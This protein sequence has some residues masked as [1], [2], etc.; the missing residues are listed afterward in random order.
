MQ[1]PQ[2]Q[3]DIS[4]SM[5]K[6]KISVY[7]ACCIFCPKPTRCSQRKSKNQNFPGGECPQTPYIAVC[8]RTELAP[9]ANILKC[10]PAL[11]SVNWGL[12]VVGG[13]RGKANEAIASEL[14]ILAKIPIIKV[15]PCH[16]EHVRTYIS[17]S[18]Y[19]WWQKTTNRHTDTHMGQL[20]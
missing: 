8:L 15:F 5:K 16:D 18:R 7:W 3:I 11:V 9:H 4:G 19:A 2:H 17:G 6:P 12:S 13:I 10:N 1:V 20:Q 14:S